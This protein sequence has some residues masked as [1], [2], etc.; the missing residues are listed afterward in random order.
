[1]QYKSL[2]GI[3]CSD[4]FAQVCTAGNR[5]NLERAGLMGSPALTATT[6]QGDSL[7]D[8]VAMKSTRRGK[9]PFL[10]FGEFPDTCPRSWG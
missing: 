5:W 10:R 1:M 8:A 2:S 6:K 9:S 7:R 3:Q 4:F